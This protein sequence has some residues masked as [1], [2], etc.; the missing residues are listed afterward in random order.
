MVMEHSWSTLAV[1]GDMH[2]DRIVRRVISDDDTKFK[3][4]HYMRLDCLSKVVSMA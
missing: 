3:R 1:N 4:Y 2:V